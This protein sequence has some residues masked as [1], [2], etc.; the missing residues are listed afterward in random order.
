VQDIVSVRTHMTQRL[1]QFRINPR[2]NSE[3]ARP[4]TAEE[5]DKF[6]ASVE[7]TA[8]NLKRCDNDMMDR[9][10]N[11]G[12]IEEH[13][14]CVTNGRVGRESFRADLN[15]DGYKTWREEEDRPLSGAGDSQFKSEMQ[16]AQ[17]SEG[18][19]AGVTLTGS[20]DG[21]RETAFFVDRNNPAGSLLVQH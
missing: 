10:R 20:P 5:V 4:M 2:P 13:E 7:N 17:V 12:V 15:P 18:F 1:E 16:W 19:I 11:S 6:A 9:N 14:H 8:A 21:V 3:D